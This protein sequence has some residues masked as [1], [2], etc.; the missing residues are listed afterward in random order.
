MGE[1][2]R[3]AQLFSA[4]IRNFEV[5]RYKKEVFAVK[6]GPT[7]GEYVPKGSDFGQLALPNFLLRPGLGPGQIILE[8]VGH[9]GAD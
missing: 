9:V 7:G 5:Q 3:K 1:I 4:L 6:S 8:T 2:I